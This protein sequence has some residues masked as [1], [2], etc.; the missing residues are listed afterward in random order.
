MQTDE[1]QKPSLKQLK[2]KMK[3][4]PIDDA[5]EQILTM[6][7][8]QNDDYIQ[9]TYSLHNSQKALDKIRQDLRQMGPV[10]IDIR[11]HPIRYEIAMHNYTLEHCT[12][13]I[14]RI[15]ANIDCFAQLHKEIE[16]RIQK[17]KDAEQQKKFQE[18]TQ[19]DKSRIQL[20]PQFHFLLN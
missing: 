4:I 3:L 12:K 19:N 2:S 13:E 6:M 14:E 11:K 16:M 20:I 8:Y 15:K 10:K 17:Q 9:Q 5:K 1:A 18:A 7:K